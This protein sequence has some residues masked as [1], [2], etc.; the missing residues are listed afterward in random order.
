[1]R[2]QHTITDYLPKYIY[3]VVLQVMGEALANLK[4]N[5][6]PIGKQDHIGPKKGEVTVHNYIV[7][8][9]MSNKGHRIKG[10]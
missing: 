9:I 10:H 6:P 4:D 5:M 8:V 2:F 3:L 1:M 7:T